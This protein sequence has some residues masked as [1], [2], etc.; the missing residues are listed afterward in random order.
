MLLLYEMGD[1]MHYYLDNKNEDGKNVYI[2]KVVR[3]DDKGVYHVT[4]ANGVCEDNV[5]LSKDNA[6]KIEERL[7]SQIEE[8]VKNRYVLQRKQITGTIG[9]VSL[10]ILASLG[11]FYGTSFVT[12]NFNIRL[13]SA[14]VICLGG[15]LW[16]ALKYR[17][18]QVLLQEIDDYQYRKKYLE[19]VKDYFYHSSNASNVFKKKNSKNRYERYHQLN[20]MINEGRDPFQ[21]IETDNGGITRSEF[22]KLLQG[23]HR[24]KELGLTY[25]KSK[26]VG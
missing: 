18:N 6:I 9:R 22:D 3:D 24:E 15:I 11:A 20:S 5:L 12:D 13:L 2:N 19:D 25:V 26:T 4:F 21:L 7:E 16:G 14:G 1:F 10:G 23:S 17:H 8:G